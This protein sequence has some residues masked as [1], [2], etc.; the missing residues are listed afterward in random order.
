METR[1]RKRARTD[2]TRD[3]GLIPDILVK[4]LLFLDVCFLAC[5]AQRVCKAWQ[6]A[7]ACTTALTTHV[8]IPRHVKLTEQFLAL[9]KFALSPKT[10][11]LT[12][13]CRYYRHPEHTSVLPYRVLSNLA[14]ART[15]PNL[16]SLDLRG[17]DFGDDCRPFIATSLYHVL[18]EAPLLVLLKRLVFPLLGA[19]FNFGD[20]PSPRESLAHV[21]EIEMD[22][23]LINT[24]K[25]TE[26]RTLAPKLTRVRLLLFNGSG[27]ESE[28]ALCDAISGLLTEA[29]R[30]TSVAIEASCGVLEF[31][32]SI[33]RVLN[34]CILTALGARGSSTAASAA[35]SSSA[36]PASG[37]NA[38]AAAAPA[39]AAPA[40]PAAQT[41]EHVGVNFDCVPASTVQ[42]LCL[43]EAS[44]TR[45]TW[46]GHEFNAK[47]HLIKSRVALPSTV[48]DMQEQDRRADARPGFLRR[49]THGS[50]VVVGGAQWM[51]RERQQLIL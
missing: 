21:S 36:A 51:W 41:L 17:P 12:V 18:K 6:R 34:R 43:M 42:W 8:V 5:A 38:A 35:T 22:I 44:G 26:I 23:P 24:F 48:A 9:R 3:K 2:A 28:N 20:L 16:T 1:A 7:V 14:L 32:S 33:H 47:E 11:A 40:A 49:C 10:R 13:A 31:N 46:S 15:C 45:I 19:W 25:L 4:A 39:V 29:T 37:S 30:L 50:T 27:S